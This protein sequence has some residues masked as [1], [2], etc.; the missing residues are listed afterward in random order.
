MKVDGIEEI[1]LKIDRIVAGGFSVVCYDKRFVAMLREDDTRC[2]DCGALVD[3]RIEI[4]TPA[5][6][7][8]GIK[9]RSKK[10]C[11]K[12]YAK[13]EYKSVIGKKEAA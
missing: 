6:G 7:D 13:D 1:N 9:N 10:I 3:A 11:K 12:C 5:K 8:K 2:A 4:I